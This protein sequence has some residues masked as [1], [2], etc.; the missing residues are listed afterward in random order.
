[1]LMGSVGSNPVS[2]S[3]VISARSGH[4]VSLDGQTSLEIDLDLDGLDL[5]ECNSNGLDPSG[6]YPLND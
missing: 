3:L 2:S 5:S 4:S 6:A 1:M